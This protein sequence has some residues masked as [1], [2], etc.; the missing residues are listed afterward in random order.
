MT[1][2][3]EEVQPWRRVLLQTFEMTLTDPGLF[4]KCPNRKTQLQLPL[5]YS[6]IKTKTLP[7]PS[8]SL[9]V[10][11]VVF[12]AVTWHMIRIFG[13]GPLGFVWFKWPSS[14]FSANRSPPPPIDYQ[15][16]R[17]EM[18]NQISPEGLD[19]FYAVHIHVYI[20]KLSH[21]G[22]FRTLLCYQKLKWARLFHAERLLQSWK[23]FQK[24]EREQRRKL[25]VLLC[26]MGYLAHIKHNKRMPFMSFFTI[27]PFLTY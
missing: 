15:V 19:S 16:C 10:L 11:S 24:P 17:P 3:P 7:V 20:I 25:M 9:M 8:L 21:K 26:N 1:P 13:R 23:L 2:S 27:P 14:L 18:I 22:C 5:I 12:L 4:K 6:A